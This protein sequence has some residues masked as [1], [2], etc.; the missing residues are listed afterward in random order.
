[1]QKVVS[2]VLK[3]TQHRAEFCFDFYESPSIKDK[4]LKERRNEE[5][6]WAFFIGPKT[7]TE[8]DMHDMLK[9]FCFKEGLF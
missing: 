4:K 6:D 2:S 7:K 8:T 1:M 5:F 9:V 3:L